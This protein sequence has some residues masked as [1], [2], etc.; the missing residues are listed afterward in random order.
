MYTFNKFCTF[1][2]C[3]F[4]TFISSKCSCIKHNH[5]YRM[6]NKRYSIICFNHCFP[7]CWWN[8]GIFLIKIIFT[9]SFSLNL[10]ILKKYFSILQSDR[11]TI[12]KNLCACLLVAELIFMFGIEWT[13]HRVIC[14]LI[15]AL[16]HYFFLAA[17]A[18]MFLEGNL[19]LLSV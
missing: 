16:L 2:G 13:T 6:W 1:D 8:E 4:S 14:G 17:F 19:L 7:M 3:P 5:I 15:A 11:I 10:L 18:W 12:H 9:I